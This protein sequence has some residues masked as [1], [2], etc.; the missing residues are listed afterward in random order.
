MSLATHYIQNILKE[1]QRYKSLGDR[2]FAQLEEDEIHWRMSDEGN[3]IAILVKHMVGNMLSR[4]TDFL[5]ADGEKPWRKRDMEFED[6]F[7]SKRE[8]IES[9]EKGW[10]CVFDAV[11]VLDQDNFDTTVFIR[12]EKHSIIEALNRQLGHYAYHTGQIVMTA[13]SIRGNQ[14]KSLTIPKGKSEDFNK[15]MFE[16]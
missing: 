9:W 2:T 10:K 11:A 7:S 14:W 5:T 3:S 13:K 8:M 15:T 6:P 1:F 16:K 12:K 4:F